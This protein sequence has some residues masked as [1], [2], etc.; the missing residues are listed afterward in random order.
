MT[1]STEVLNRINAALCIT[2]DQITGDALRDARD[3]IIDMT[4]TTACH[5]AN[6]KPCGTGVYANT[7]DAGPTAFGGRNRGVRRYD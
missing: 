6:C 1:R 7:R 3:L 4:H 2:V 5:L